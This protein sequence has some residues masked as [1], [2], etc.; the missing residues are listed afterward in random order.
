MGGWWC[1]GGGDVVGVGKIAWVYLPGLVI[2][3][4]NNLKTNITINMY[5]THVFSTSRVVS[6]ILILLCD[7]D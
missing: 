1:G 2:L 6:S 7:N 5:W 4:I 3:D